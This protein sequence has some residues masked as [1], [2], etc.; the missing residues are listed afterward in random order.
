MKIIHTADWHIGKNLNDYS[1]LED[2]KYYFDQFVKKLAE[3]KPDVL[4][5]AGDLYDRSIPFSEAIN[6]LNAILC[7]IV[8]K[9]KIQTLIVAGNHDSKER[10]SFGSELLE[11]SG[12]HIAGNITKEIKKVTIQGVNFYLVPYIEPHNIKQLYPEQTIKSHDQAMKQYTGE[13]LKSLDKAAVNIMVGHG[14]FGY[15]ASSD[16]SVGGSELVDS[17]I[18][19]DFDYVALGHLH[20]RRTAGSEKMVFSGSPL[21][22]SID[23]TGQRKSFTL[24]ELSGKSQIKTSQIELTPLRDVRVL[25]GSFDYLNNRDN[26]DNREDYVF[27]NITDDKMVLNAISRLKAVFPNVIGLKY[28]NLNFA[29]GDGFIKEKSQVAK[30]SELDL[31]ENFYFDVTRQELDETSKKYIEAAMKA[32][33]GE[34]NDTD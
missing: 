19:E 1:L 16:V 24:L 29:A 20:A 10:L 27:M 23:E 25:E 18:F 4:I 31:F 3:L 21:K 7:E 28:C 33:R 26:F 6:L 30:L 32:A 8:L 15:G 22:Y 14:L 12:L 17:S 13:M 5:I 2:Q 9:H 34:Q 11:Q